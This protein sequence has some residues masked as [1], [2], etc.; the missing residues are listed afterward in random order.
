MRTFIF[1]DD[2]MKK[3][4]G[5]IRFD[6]ICE[7]AH[8]LA[9]KKV[10]RKINK[11]QVHHMD[12]P[13]Y[14][15]WNNTDKRVYKTSPELDR[16]NSLNTYGKNTWNSPDRN[17]KYIAQHFSIFPN[18][19]ITTGRDLNS[20]P[21]GIKGWNQGAICVEIYGDFDYKQDV[22]T[23]SQKKSVIALYALLC[24]KFNLTPGPNTIRPHCWFTSSGTYLG[25][26]KPL[27]SAKS[28]PG[29]NFMEIGNT[30]SAFINKFYPM[31]K[32]HMEN[33][34]LSE[35]T[36]ATNTK[37]KMIKNISKESINIRDDADWNGKVV[38]VLKSGDSLTYM[39]GPLSAKNGTTMMYR[40]KNDVYLT[41]SSKYTR[42]I[43]V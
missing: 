15:T 22:M 1:G 17:G 19:K 38:G 33:N 43:Y 32:N 4:Y 10:S 18:G 13:N 41:A 40:C 31:I 25:D 21:I 35:N 28:C 9:N 14:N 12:L 6:N 8:W 27:K 23:S 36:P 7:F 3:Q 34:D 29:T 11:L 2:K 37:K 39:A 26:Y 30:K 16:T 24:E 20:T 42:L 5:F